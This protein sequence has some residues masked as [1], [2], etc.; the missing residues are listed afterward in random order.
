MKQKLYYIIALSRMNVFY[1]S[2]I[3]SYSNLSN[4]VTQTANAT[5]GKMF[6]YESDFISKH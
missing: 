5:Q 4:K 3:V 6:A 2:V 1:F